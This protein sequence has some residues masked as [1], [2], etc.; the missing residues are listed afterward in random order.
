MRPPEEDI[1]AALEVER[2]VGEEE[3]D[4]YLSC[5]NELPMSQR[6][7]DQELRDGCILTFNIFGNC[8]SNLWRQ[9]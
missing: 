8:R 7:T 1:Q 9:R 4:L 3:L 2:S 6:V 5:L